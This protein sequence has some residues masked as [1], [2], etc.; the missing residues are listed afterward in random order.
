M[1]NQ[2]WSTV[3]I[4]VTLAVIA[5]GLL[6][7]GTRNV[8]AEPK[9]SAVASV[10]DVIKI[11]TPNDRA[12]LCQNPNCDQDQEI[13][14]IPTNTELKVESLIRHRMP[15]WDVVWYKVTYQGK[16]GWVSEFDTNVAP[17]EPRYR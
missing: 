4:F 9:M 5:V 15:L 7:G 13:L 6:P 17:N 11:V 1:I 3:G 14:R 8:N 12:R 10:G 2:R 16:R